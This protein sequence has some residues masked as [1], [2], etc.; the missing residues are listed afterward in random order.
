MVGH[1]TVPSTFGRPEL[2][3]ERSRAARKRAE[4]AL[5]LFIHELGNFEPP[6]IVMG[7]LVP[8]I[9]TRDQDP[10]VPRHLGTTDVDV[11]IDFQVA[12]D[13]DLNPIEEALRRV[14][15][16]PQEGSNGWRWLGRVGGA[17]VKLEFLCEFDDRP[18]ESVVR[19]A[20]C[21]L[22]GAMNLRGTG[23]V[24]EDW[25]MEKITG[26]LPGGRTVTVEAR[27]AGLCGY[28][29]AKAIALRERSFDKDYYDFAYVLAYN[30]LGGPAQAA[31]ALKEGQ[32]A[33]R[34]K[35]MRTVW[36]EVADRFDA[37]DRLGSMAYAAQAQ[38]A[39]PTGDDAQLR[40]EA[41]AAVSEFFGVLD[42]L[43]WGQ[44]LF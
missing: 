8:D 9:L 34:L 15:F 23:Y 11:L 1:G 35:G 22:L 38:L 39:D 18:A 4:D 16:A 28:L 31:Q 7:G 27:F 43:D 3:S 17:P 24:R 42:V 14:G 37:P 33:N 40:Q 44:V 19:P 41:V 29:L 25:Q 10:P 26:T 5:V 2:D 12:A 30:R 36:R 21:K 13:E 32:F 6:L 20:G